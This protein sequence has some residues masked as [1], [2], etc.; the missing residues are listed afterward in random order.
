M[1]RR[2]YGDVFIHADNRV[3]SAKH[4][5][6]METPHK[7]SAV[8]TSTTLTFIGESTARHG[9]GKV[10]QRRRH[11]DVSRRHDTSRSA[12][13]QLW[14][15]RRQRSLP[16]ANRWHHSSAGRNFDGMTPAD[17]HKSIYGVPYKILNKCL[18]R[19]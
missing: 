12:R 11:D 19:V 5:H 13:H 6:D 18:K 3:A 10:L 16:A 8:G 7:R 17:R 1:S 4:R 14:V 2:W 15:S 9:G